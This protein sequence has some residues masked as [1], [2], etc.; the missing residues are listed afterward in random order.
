MRADRL[1]L[2]EAFVRRLAQRVLP[3]R[4]AQ[5]YLLRWYGDEEA[6]SYIVNALAKKL[7]IATRTAWRECKRAQERLQPLLLAEAA[8]RQEKARARA[9][10]QG[11]A[12]APSERERYDLTV[13]RGQECETVVLE[14]EQCALTGQRPGRSNWKGRGD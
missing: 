9:R 10:T 5:V 7:G 4:Q 6:P 14:T 2:P 13:E 12:T 11:A 3:A 1:V 8:D